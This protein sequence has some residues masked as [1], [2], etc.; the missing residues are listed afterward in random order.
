MLSIE[1]SR[2]LIPNGDQYSDKQVGEI[3]DSTHSLVEII[4]DKWMDERTQEEMLKK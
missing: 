1:K 2:K 4:F 3:R